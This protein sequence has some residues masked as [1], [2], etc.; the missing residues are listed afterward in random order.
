MS[1]IYIS[2]T[3]SDL[4]EY[5]V[6]V[7]ETLRQLGHYV[8]SME[9]YVAEDKLPLQK[10]FE[11]IEQCDIYIGIFGWRYGFIPTVSNPK[12]LSIAEREY[13]HAQEKNVTSLIFLLDETA[14]YLPQK[15]DAFTGEGKRGARIR[16]FREILKGI[17]LSHFTIH[18]MI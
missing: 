7:I 15:M 5:R 11:G 12:K 17:S 1:K 2:S 14:E 3:F 13:R 10:C 8:L 16:T 6:K 4:Q 9:D 18:P